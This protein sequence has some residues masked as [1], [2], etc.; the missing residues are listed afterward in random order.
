[1]NLYQVWDKNYEWCCF[2]FDTSRNKAKLRV[3]ESFFCD[4]ID[5]RC[6]TVKKGVNVQ[7]PMLV[8]HPNAEGYDMVLYYGGRY[9][10]DVEAWI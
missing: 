6:M 8:D 5:M 10:Q 3:A 2:A 7:V 9:E 1:M 4:Y